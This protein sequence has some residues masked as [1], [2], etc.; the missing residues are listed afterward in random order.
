MIC[1]MIL[2]PLNDPL[3][4]RKTTLRLLTC[5]ERRISHFMLIVEN[6]L[7]R[8]VSYSAVGFGYV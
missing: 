7:S 4:M 5:M 2:E 1:V 8:L 3:L 6:M